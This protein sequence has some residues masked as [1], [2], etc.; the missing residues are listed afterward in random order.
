MPIDTDQ[1]ALISPQ[2]LWYVSGTAA[3]VAVGWLAAKL[4]TVGFAPVGLLPLG[5]G[6]LLGLALTALAA[7]LRT[8]RATRL[9]V[10]T[11]VLVLV[12]VA[13][14][15]A[16]LYRDFRRQWHDARTR[17]PQIA[18]FRPESPWS[19]TE[20]FERELTSQRATL[21]AVDATLIVAGAVATVIVWRR[22]NPET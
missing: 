16:W 19:A 10:G 5:I 21:W 4:Q 1:R 18:M 20:Y 15:H 3:A 7:A 22:L 17:E 6:C 12:A 11:I 2:L 9:V 8:P 14:E 13:A